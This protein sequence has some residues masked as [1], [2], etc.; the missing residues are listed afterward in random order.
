MTSND[1]LLTIR[2]FF[3]ETH[4]DKALTIADDANLFEAEMIDS[5]GIISLV[6]FLE[7]EFSVAL[8]YEDMT[9]ENFI[10]LNALRTMVDKAN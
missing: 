10:N 8:D 3:A 1:T 2:K 5:L 7:E 6:M 9:E 4:P